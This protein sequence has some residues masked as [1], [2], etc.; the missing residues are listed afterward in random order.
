MA[1]PKVI[2]VVCCF[3]VPSKGDHYKVLQER[4][5][6][7]CRVSLPNLLIPGPNRFIAIGYSDDPVSMLLLEQTCSKY[8]TGVDMSIIKL[9]ENVGKASALDNAM[10]T[11]SYMN[12]KDVYVLTCD[13]DILIHDQTLLKT[14]VHLLQSAPYAG[15]VAPNQIGTDC[16]HL[17]TVYDNRLRYSSELTLHWSDDVPHSVAGGC[18]MFKFA[19]VYQKKRGGFLNYKVAEDVDFAWFVGRNLHLRCYMVQERFVEHNLKQVT[20]NQ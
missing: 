3:Y 9:G 12:A 16:R 14:L 11:I 6:E 19:A 8:G 20:E 10:V 2:A 5:R 4:F 13:C 15:L 18:W 1:A 7:F 17:A